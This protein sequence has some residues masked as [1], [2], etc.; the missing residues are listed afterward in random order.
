MYFPHSTCQI[1]ATDIIFKDVENVPEL[2]FNIRALMIA[3][4]S[5]VIIYEAVMLYYSRKIGRISVK[6]IM[7]ETE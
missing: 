5:F 1:T 3:A 4:V 7:M 2:E 6:E